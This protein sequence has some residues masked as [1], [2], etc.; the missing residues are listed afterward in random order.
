LRPDRF[1]LYPLAN[2]HSEVAV[3]RE[4]WFDKVLWSYMPC[5][6]KGWAI[7]FAL[8]IPTVLTILLGQ[9]A[10]VYLGWKSIDGLPFLLIFPAV[11]WLSAIAKRHS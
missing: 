11:L 2:G 10:F 7:L 5:H 1:W 3:E 6:W 4:I 9:A 8:I